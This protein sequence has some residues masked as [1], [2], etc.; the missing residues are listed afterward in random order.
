ML[1]MSKIIILPFHAICIHIIN[2]RGYNLKTTCLVSL[3]NYIRKR[4]KQMEFN[5][6][7]NSRHF[8]LISLSFM[9]VEAFR[10]ICA[11]KK[12]YEMYLTAIPG[13]NIM[14][15]II[16]FDSIAMIQTLLDWH[17]EMKT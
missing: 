14:I 16:S 9:A 12:T 17:S 3:L 10:I 8:C 2:C 11:Q 13:Q 5:R 6:S 15:I 4:T 7:L 1:C